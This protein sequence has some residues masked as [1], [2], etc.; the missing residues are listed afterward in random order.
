MIPRGERGEPLRVDAEVAKQI[1]ADERAKVLAE[2]E[3]A[4]EVERIDSSGQRYY[5]KEVCEALD[6]LR[7]RLAAKGQR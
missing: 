5:W 6:R 4:I 3:K 7:A 2:V 1:R